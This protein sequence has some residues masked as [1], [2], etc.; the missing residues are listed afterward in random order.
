MLRESGLNFITAKGMKDGAE[1]AVRAA[2]SASA[3]A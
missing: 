2:R 3:A 1:Q